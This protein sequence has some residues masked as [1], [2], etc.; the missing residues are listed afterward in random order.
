MKKITFNT[1]NE[2]NEAFQAFQSTTLS[3]ELTEKFRVKPFF[4]QYASLKRTVLFASYIINV[5]AVVTSFVG[6]F[7][8]LEALVHSTILAA[9]FAS[10]FLVLI[11]LLKRFTIPKTVKEWLQFRKISVPLLFFSVVLIGLSIGLSYSGA[12]EAVQLFTPQA[13]VTDV[14][15]PKKEYTDRIKQLEKQKKEIKRTM[16]WQSKLTPQGAKAY[17]EITAQIGHIENDMLQNINRITTNNDKTIQNHSE[18]TT[19]KSSYFALFTLFFDLSLIVAFIFMEYYDYRSFTEFASSDSDTHNSSY[20]N[21]NVATDEPIS[22]NVTSQSV[23]TAN[24]GFSLNASTLQL[25]I[26]KAK[27]NISAYQSKISKGEGR[28][29]TNA[30]GMERWND[31]LQELEQMQPMAAS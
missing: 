18:T 6:V 12:H 8:F 10:I 20:D 2:F 29:E 26:K 21:T 24:N 30:Q 5:F 23:A 19:A 3:K 16:S 4:E 25:A 7:A 11:E 15:T 9:I 31:K 13:T 28:T 27:S 1:S 22:G 14:A 17:N